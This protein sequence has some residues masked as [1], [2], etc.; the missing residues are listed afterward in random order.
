MKKIKMRF[1][2]KLYL[3]TEKFFEKHRKYIFAGV[4]FFI[5]CQAVYFIVPALIPLI[6]TKME[7]SALEKEKAYYIE[8]IRRDSIHIEQLK[9]DDFL[10]Q[11]ARE[12]YFMQGKDEQIFIV[13]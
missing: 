3:R 11:Y 2:Y 8:S 12:K 10:E 9:N 7:I 13:E 1:L 6:K 5:V 4:L